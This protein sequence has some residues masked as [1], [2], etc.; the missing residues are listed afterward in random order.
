MNARAKVLAVNGVSLRAAPPDSLRPNP[1][2][3]PP[4]A[5]PSGSTTPNT[6]DQRILKGTR[7]DWRQH[8]L[9]WVLPVLFRLRLWRIIRHLTLVEVAREKENSRRKPDE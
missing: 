2:V 5:I 1:P 7:R 9:R 3:P 6:G 4:L 8:L